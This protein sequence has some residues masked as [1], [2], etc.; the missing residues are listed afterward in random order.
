MAVEEGEAE[1]LVKD[2]EVG[3]TQ[4][5]AS[6]ADLPAGIPEISRH[7]SQGIESPLCRACRV[8]QLKSV[9]FDAVMLALAVELDQRFA[10]LVAYLNDHFARN[11]PTVDLVVKLSN[12]NLNAVE[13]FQ[14]PAIKY[15]LLV[16][17]GDGP[18]AGL[19]LRLAPAFL[20]RMAGLNTACRIRE[21]VR[22]RC[23]EGLQLEELVIGE[24]QRVL[25]RHWARSLQ[26]APL[27]PLVLV[28]EQGAGRATAAQAASASVRRSLVEV[29]WMPERAENIER[30]RAAAREALWHDATLLVRVA[31]SS[32]DPDLA[33]LWANLA[34]WDLPL[35]LA[36]PLT[37][38]NLCAR[39]LPLSL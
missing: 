3:F 25:L 26:S 16:A 4:E 22:I 7:H 5:L 37:L 18:L 36:T 33:S 28:G 6:P 34:D 19:M 8:F 39:L 20:H 31:K 10:R 21:G 14:R 23:D 32:H 1:E 11:R 13:F 9:D 24:A 30:L 12:T 27:L 17:E 29:A 35:A 38:P 15:G 2:L